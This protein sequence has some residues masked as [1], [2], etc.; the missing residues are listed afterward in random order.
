MFL[1][2]SLHVCSILGTHSGRLSPVQDLVNTLKHTPANNND[3]LPLKS[4]TTDVVGGSQCLK[5]TKNGTEN[6]KGDKE[7]IKELIR[8]SLGIAK[9]FNTVV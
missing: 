9:D 2:D 6:S 7:L 8:E 5:C 4:I 1:N 3:H